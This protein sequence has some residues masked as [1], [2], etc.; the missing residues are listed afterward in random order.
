[1]SPLNK[2]SHAH[3]LGIR[4][5][6]HGPRARDHEYSRPFKGMYLPSILECL[7][8]VYQEIN[9]MDV[10]FQ[11][12]STSLVHQ[13]LTYEPSNLQFIASKQ[14]LLLCE[15]GLSPWVSANYVLYIY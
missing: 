9:S 15:K 13:V 2:T 11:S 10:N 12:I 1:M 6:T 8:G 7:H 5:F 4:A 3:L 14:C